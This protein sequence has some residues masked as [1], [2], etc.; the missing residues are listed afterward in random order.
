MIFIIIIYIIHKKNDFSKIK[1]FLGTYV[2][3]HRIYICNFKKKKGAHHTKIKLKK[4]LKIQFFRWDKSIC[5]NARLIYFD[6]IFGIQ[7]YSMEFYINNF[8][9]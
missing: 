1:N 5:I 9:F 2:R 7:A 8:F 4:V 6:K 3:P